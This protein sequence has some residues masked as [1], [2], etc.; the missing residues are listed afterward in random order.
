V[1]LAVPDDPSRGQ[2]GLV[3]V[4]GVVR[5]LIEAAFFGFA[6]WAL[7]DL[8]EDGLAIGYGSAA[9]LHYGLSFD[10]VKWLIRQ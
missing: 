6:T 9:V 2:N 3:R 8:G 5:L 1:G 7:H 10:R 4:P